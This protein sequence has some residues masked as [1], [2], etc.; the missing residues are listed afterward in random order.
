MM[1][2]FSKLQTFLIIYSTAFTQFLV[3]LVCF[4]RLNTRT[5][6][7]QINVMAFVFTLM[8]LLCVIFG[9]LWIMWNLN[10]YMVH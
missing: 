4:L 6:Q 8:I 10:F 7:G 3:Q 5:E 1:G 9:S 2:Q